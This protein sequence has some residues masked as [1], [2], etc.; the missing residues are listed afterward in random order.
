MEPQVHSLEE[1]SLGDILVAMRER[2]ASDLYIGAGERPCFRIRGALTYLP[3]F[4]K[5]DTT[6]AKRLVYSV[7]KDRQKAAFEASMELDLS[8]QY[9]GVARFRMNVYQQRGTVSCVVRMLP[10]RPPTLQ[11]LGLSPK[12]GG[13]VERPHGLILVCGATGSGKSST[14]AALIEHINSTQARHIITLEDPIEFVFPNKSSYIDQ[15]EINTDTL[16]FNTALKYVLRQNPDVI[17]I[18]EIRD[19]ESMGAALKAAETGHLVMGTLHT[20]NAI[21][22]V[23]RVIDFF[24]PERQSQVRGQL[25][26]VLEGVIA[27]RLVPRSDRKGRIAA[28]EIMQVTPAIRNKIRMNKVEQILSDLQV[29]I[30]TGCKTLAAHMVELVTTGVVSEE[31]AMAAMDLGQA[32]E[33]TT[34]LRAYEA[35]QGAKLDEPRTST[36]AHG[37][38]N[39]PQAPVLRPGLTPR[40]PGE[41]GGKADIIVR[42]KEQGKGEE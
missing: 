24:P 33:F 28:M 19:E 9:Q 17:I 35:K 36:H 41:R 37:H 16:S 1:L 40:K 21:S 3:Q 7:L 14:I 2:G 10:F 38:A 34:Y 31:A 8:F 5:L 27:Q 11:E 23:N 39:A 22:T 42:S 26:M 29:G 15:R 18:G 13:L 30:E 25:S 32:E 12:L 4:P 6:T 20:N